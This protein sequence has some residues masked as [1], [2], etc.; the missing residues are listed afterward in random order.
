MTRL[1]QFGLAFAVVLLVGCASETRAGVV[2]SADAG[3][4][5]DS[6]TI[7]THSGDGLTSD[8]A[9]I[10]GELAGRGEGGVGCLWLEGPDGQ[11]AILWPAGYSA[12]FSPVQLIGPEGSVV[13][14]EG[15]NLRAS[16]GY[17]P[18]VDMAECRLG[19]GQIARIDRI[20]EVR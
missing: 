7:P 18:A 3:S 4:S 9:E 11:Q 20:I 1:L 8:T 6:S 2:G 19:Q 17:G 14:Q 15:Q 5:Q 13:A 10:V 16:G 12:T